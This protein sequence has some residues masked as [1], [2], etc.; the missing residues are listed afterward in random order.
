M[1]KLNSVFFFFIFSFYSFGQ[2]GS[3]ESS[4]LCNEI[5]KGNKIG[6]TVFSINCLESS[7]ILKDIKDGIFYYKQ[8]TGYKSKILIKYDSLNR[9][10]SYEYKYN[11]GL[12]SSQ[13][14][15]FF[16]INYYS[17][18]NLKSYFRLSFDTGTGFCEL[19]EFQEEEEERDKLISKIFFIY[20][21]KNKWYMIN[22]I[23]SSNKE[24]KRYIKNN[25]FTT[26]NEFGE[27]DF[28]FFIVD[29]IPH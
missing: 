7:Y 15:G 5:P 4:K 17:N 19:Y 28:D 21:Y 27:K 18:G 24:K 8:I 16:K 6:D 22:K 20:R 11:A 26:F 1:R 13:G 14:H 9:V 3:T 25:N 12:W 23:F 2:F 10:K 29:L